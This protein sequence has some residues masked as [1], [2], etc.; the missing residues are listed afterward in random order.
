MTA[1]LRSR[2]AI[3]GLGAPVGVASVY[4]GGGAMVVPLA[5]LAAWSAHEF[6]HLFS[7]RQADRRIGALGVVGAAGLVVAAGAAPALADWG[8]AAAV[9]LVALALVAS[10]TAALCW[11]GGGQPLASTCVAVAAAVYAGG[12]LS[13]AV[14]LRGLPGTWAEGAPGA[15]EGPLLA[16]LPLAVVW[17]GDSAA[18]AVGRKAGRRRLA[19]RVSPGKTVEGCIAGLAAAA[20]TGWA[21]GLAFGDL[22]NLPLSPWSGLAGGLALGAAGQIGDLA[23]SAF[24]RGAGVKDSGSLLGGHGGVLDRFDGVY[25]ALPAAYGLALLARSLA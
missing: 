15:W 7:D 18:Y 24:K 25:F 2:L 17:V 12:T 14:F 20:A 16:L 19:P 23:E 21:A 8:G 22:P 11:D 4:V 3:A 5:G 10:G 1:N 13:F 6:C 9:L